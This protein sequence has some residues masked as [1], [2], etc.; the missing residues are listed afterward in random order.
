MCQPVK[1]TG[2]ASEAVDNTILIRNDLDGSMRDCIRTNGPHGPVQETSIRQAEV[3]PVEN[4]R[5]STCGSRVTDNVKPVAGD[6]RSQEQRF[7]S[8]GKE[9]ACKGMLRRMPGRHRRIAA[10][11]RARNRCRQVPDRGTGPSRP[12]TRVAIGRPD[13]VVAADGFEPPTKRL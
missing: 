1:Q 7:P 13:A 2:T 11:G 5:R 12:A 3:A 4:H 6:E 10:S 8:R 9:G